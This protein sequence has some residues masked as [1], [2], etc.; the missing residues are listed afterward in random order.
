MKNAD[1]L[2]TI[3]FETRQDW[4]VWLKERHADTKGLWLKIAKK[5]TSIPSL[6]YAEALEVALCY[7]WIDGQKASFDDQ[8][9]LQKFTP[10]GSKSIWSKVNCDKVM[11]LLAEG[12]M[13]PAGIQQV[14]RAQADG[15]WEA[16]Y[17]SQSKITIPDDFQS[18]L[19]KNQQ[20]QEFF[21]TLNSVNRYAIL[22]RIQTAKRPETRSARIQKFIEMLAQRQKIHP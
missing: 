14:E 2:P 8:Y 12:R 17:E 20:A 10:R 11:A 19:D 6:S 7:G 3:S 16:A 13:Q 1:I 9:W 4:E 5:G 15:R 21:N 18:E 22:F